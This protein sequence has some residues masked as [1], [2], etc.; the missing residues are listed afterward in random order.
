MGEN[1]VEEQIKHFERRRN[2]ARDEVTRRS[3]FERPEISDT[4]YT[5][6]FDA[7]RSRKTAIRI[8]PPSRATAS[9]STWSAATESWAG[10]RAKEPST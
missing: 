7:A 9:G 10:L 1:F 4:E 5:V 8:S 3:L 2:L 6:T